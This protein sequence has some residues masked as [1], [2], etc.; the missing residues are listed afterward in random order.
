M[1]VKKVII[2]YSIIVALVVIISIFYRYT[3]KNSDSILFVNHNSNYYYALNHKGLEK[4]GDNR[5]KS[6]NLT[7]YDKQTKK[8]KKYNFENLGDTKDIVINP[9]NMQSSG[10]WIIFKSYSNE[11]LTGININNGDVKILV[12]NLVTEKGKIY[13]LKDFSVY[14]NNIIYSYV[15]NDTTY[16]EIMNIKDN[17]RTVIAKFN[18]SVDVPVTIYGDKAAYISDSKIY[19]YDLTNKKIIKKSDKNYS[20]EF[21]LYKDKI[22][23]FK[24]T[25][26]KY[27]LVSLDFNM[28]ETEILKNINRTDTLYYDK[29]KL[30][31]SDYFYD[32][33]NNQ[34]YIRKLHETSYKPGRLILGDYIFNGNSKYEKLKENKNYIKASSENEIY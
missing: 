25:L 5:I 10:D 31:Y 17:K 1:K 32:T 15:S 12:N 11:G 29:D 34:L 27:S 23:T 2:I 14:K 22:Y 20:T 30:I 21:L 3:Y 9:S 7:T 6:F 33:N 4:N 8:E 18:N 28:K 16:V 19:L 13:S 24:S 26:D